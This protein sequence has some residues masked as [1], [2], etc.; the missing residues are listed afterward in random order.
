MMYD[1]MFSNFKEREINGVKIYSLSN[2]AFGIYRREAR[3]D[4]DIPRDILEVKLNAMILSTNIIKSGFNGKL[5][6]RFGGFCITVNPRTE[7]IE[8]VSWYKEDHYNHGNRKIM[9]NKLE[10]NYELLG[11]NKEGNNYIKELVAV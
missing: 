2:E 11:L 6:Y 9:T 8:T 10:K 5:N 1:S 7:K 4:A 3:R